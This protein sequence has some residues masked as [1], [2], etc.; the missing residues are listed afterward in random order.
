M[1]PQYELRA[2]SRGHV[3]HV[4]MTYNDAAICGQDCAGFGVL[5][6]YQD[7]RAV[8]AKHT[9]QGWPASWCRRC[10]TWLRRWP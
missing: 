3:P 10:V 7:H 1:R 8:L 5:E 9:D 2:K 4:V 6:G